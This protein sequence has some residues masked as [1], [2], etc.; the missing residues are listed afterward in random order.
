[1]A[2]DGVLVRAGLM[3]TVDPLIIVA[4]PSVIG[5]GSVGSPIA[6]SPAG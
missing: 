5:N 3:S 1:M 2:A 4:S 6:A